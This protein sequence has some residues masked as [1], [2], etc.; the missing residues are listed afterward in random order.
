MLM[1]DSKK[2]WKGSDYLL[3][4]NHCPSLL[5]SLY[6]RQRERGSDYILYKIEVIISYIR[7]NHSPLYCGLGY[8]NVGSERG[9]IT[10]GAKLSQDTRTVYPPTDLLLDFPTHLDGGGGH[11]PAERS[12]FLH[13]V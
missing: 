4:Y 8:N 3:G 10:S 1:K 13:I 2:E 5:P 11:K 12:L 7:Y 9:A 6:P